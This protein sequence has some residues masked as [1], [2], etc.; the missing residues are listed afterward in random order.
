M[1][2][3]SG[4]NTMV[5]PVT[6]VLH[7]ERDRQP[8]ASRMHMCPQNA[9]VCHVDVYTHA[10]WPTEPPHLAYMLAY[11]LLDASRQT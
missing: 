3:D 8:R 5:R 10:R 1:I 4:V 2:V 9:R 6:G 11:M 7:S